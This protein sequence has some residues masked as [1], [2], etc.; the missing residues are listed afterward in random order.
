[1]DEKTIKL[2]EAARKNN[3]MLED[4]YQR[5]NELNHRVDELNEQSHLS[6]EEE[7]ELA[8][9][10]KEKLHIRDQIEEIVHAKQSA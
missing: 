2:I 4:L 6:T 10:K 9:L 1:M 7:Q 5:H 3:P 8:Q